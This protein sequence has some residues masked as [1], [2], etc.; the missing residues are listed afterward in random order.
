M[1][2]PLAEVVSL[3]QPAAPGTK[4]VTGAGPWALRCTHFKQPFFT[5]I[6]DGGC[7]LE[8]DGHEPLV[9]RPHDFVLIPTACNFTVSSLVPTEPA[10]LVHASKP[11]PCLPNGEFRHGDLGAPA[12]VR[13]LVG[14]FVFASPDAALLVSLI[15]QLILVRDESRLATLVKLV[16]DESRQRRPAREVVLERLLE[17]LLIEALRCGA[18]TQPSPGLL[19]GLA[20]ERLAVAIRRL[21]ENPTLPWTV[22]QLAREAALSRSV[23]FERFGAAMGMTPME[24]LLAW[25]MAKAK[26]LLGGQHGGVAEVAARVGYSSASAFSVAFARYVGMPPARYILEVARGLDGAVLSEPE[27]GAKLETAG[28]PVLKQPTLKKPA[29]KKSAAMAVTETA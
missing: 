29:S 16:V 22:A 20:D 23:F 7:R 17:V 14:Y 19:R 24:Y 9:L 27:Q 2:D 8:V 5:V 10:D 12:D 15:P 21:H 11:P 25:R 26:S 13:F 18:D 1:I 6:L 3:L 4:I 28:E